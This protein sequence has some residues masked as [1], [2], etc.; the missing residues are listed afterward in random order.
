MKILSILLVLSAAFFI[1]T[2]LLWSSKRRRAK[3]VFWQCP[4]CTCLMTDLEMG[5]RRRVDTTCPRC[6]KIPVKRY[7]KKEMS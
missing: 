3:V 5:Y 1:L 6:G 2:V 4:N 7:I